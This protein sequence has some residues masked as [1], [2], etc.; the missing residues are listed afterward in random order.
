MINELWAKK[1]V[2]GE[3]KFSEVPAVRKTAVKT[4]LTNMYKNKEI[5]KK[6]LDAL[7]AE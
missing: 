2:N 1:V 4:L 7:L 6:E 3:V 5:T